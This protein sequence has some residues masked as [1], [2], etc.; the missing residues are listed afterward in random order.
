MEIPMNLKVVS[1]LGALVA[2]SSSFAVTTAASGELVLGFGATGGTGSS[3]NLEVALGT[4]S[5]YTALSDGNLH[6]LGRLSGADL[7]ATYGADWT[8]RAD[9]NWGIIGFTGNSLNNTVW[10]SKEQAVVGTM[11]T[12]WAKMPASGGNTA[13]SV[14]KSTVA[15]LTAAAAT[16][17][18]SYAGV[19]ETSALQSWYTTQGT[20]GSAFKTP[21]ETDTLNN[22]TAFGT[23]SYVV[24]DLFQMVNT[25]AGQSSYVGSFG[26]DNT[27]GLWFSNDA[28]DFAAIPEPSTYAMILGA[29]TLGLVA[30]RRR[31]VKQA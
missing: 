8:T 18:S 25:S 6:S 11:G 17:N 19:L 5:N 13:G 29:L 23:N 9:L 16:A 20:T 15:G 26:I 3:L 30:V 12:P 24:S 2:A 7:A 10:A 1:V 28:S 22:S 31:M 14:I 4:V 27:G 21:Y